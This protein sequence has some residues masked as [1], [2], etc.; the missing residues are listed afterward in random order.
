MKFIHKLLNKVF[1]IVRDIKDIFFAYLGKFILG[2]RQKNM[3]IIGV[4]G[5]KGKTTVVSLMSHILHN[6]GVPFGSFST[7]EQNINGKIIRNDSKLTMPGRAAINLFLKKAYNKGARVG[8]IEVTSVGL[9]QHRGDFIEWDAAVLTNLQPEHLEIHGGFENYKMCK[10]LLFKMLKKYPVKYIQN[11]KYLKTIIVNFDDPNADYFLQFNADKKIVISLNPEPDIAKIKL[12]DLELLKPTWYRADNLGIDIEIDKRVYHSNLLGDYNVY[13]VL[14]CIALSRYLNINDDIVFE[15][16]QTY[17]GTPGRMQ[18]IKTKENIA[19]VID[20]AHT[21]DSLEALYTNLRNLG[22]NNIIGVLGA[23]GAMQSQ[24]N[25]L[26]IVDTAKGGTRDEWK[27]PVMGQIVE[28]YCYKII[29]TNEDP[30]DEDP[31][32][33][34]EE[35]KAGIKDQNKVEVVVDRQLAIR[36]AI[37]LAKS[38]DIIVITGKGCEKTMMVKG[39]A[40]GSK[41]IPWTGDYELSKIYL[42]DLGKEILF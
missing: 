34:I 2:F 1:K 21:P 18:F 40:R 32:K 8:L 42:K 4:T 5:T 22:Y 28:K 7:I 35:I 11:K 6:A 36:K 9:K 10:G 31:V 27:R 24:I 14:F 3:V 33:I 16:L 23:T 19:V 13:N 12:M 38:G 15:A 20:Y 25:T 41:S 37:D 29:L 26:G 30:Y 17:T 39:G